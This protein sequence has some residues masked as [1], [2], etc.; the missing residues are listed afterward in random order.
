M[1]QV[2]TTRWLVLAHQIFPAYTVGPR[3]ESRVFNQIA[4]GARQYHCVISQKKKKNITFSC[5][6]VRFYIAPVKILQYVAEFSRNFCRNRTLNLNKFF[7]LHHTVL[8]HSYSNL[9]ASSILLYLL[10]FKCII[11]TLTLSL[12]NLA[13]KTMPYR[14]SAALRWRGWPD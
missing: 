5:I 8:N 4:H 14:E 10:Y 12:P 6:S 1:T 9:L 7:G 2:E 11:L 13:N 3:F